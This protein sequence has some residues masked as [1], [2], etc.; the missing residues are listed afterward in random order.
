MSSDPIGAAN[1]A[2]DNTPT[3]GGGATAIRNDLEAIKKIRIFHKAIVIETISDPSIVKEAP[4]SLSEFS[5]D[6]FYQAPRNSIVARI[7]DDE[8]ST[9][10]SADIVSYPFLSSHIALP[11]K[12]GE[13]VWIFKPDLFGDIRATTSYWISRVH[14]ILP[15]ED[16]NYTSP[17]RDVSNLLLT[18]SIAPDKRLEDFPNEVSPSVFVLSPPLE[19]GKKAPTKEELQGEMK[20]IVKE[21][22]EAAQV[23]MEPAPR[24][25]KRPGDLVLQGSNNTSIC[26]GIDRGF[27]HAN[28]PADRKSSNSSD[29]PAEKAGSI[30]IVAGRGRYFDTNENEIKKPRKKANIGGSKNSTAPFVVKNSLDKFEVDKD[31]AASQETDDKSDLVKEG[32]G[33]PADPG[34]QKTNPSEGDPDFLA[35]AARIYISEKSEIDKKLGLDVIKAK[36]FEAQPTPQPP[37]PV[38]AVKADH[39]RIVARKVPIKATDSILPDKAKDSGATNGSIRIVKEG[40]PTTDLACIYIEPDGTIQISGNKIYM[41]RAKDTDGGAGNGP[42]A[43]ESQPYV[44]YKELEDLWKKL[45]DALNALCTEMNAAPTPG[46]G[47]PSPKI[48]VALA[49]LKGKI[50]GIK[51]DIAKVKSDRIFGE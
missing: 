7:I 6:L 39:I 48:D 31:P 38:V 15:L 10:T 22:A 14:D 30:D 20:R 17:T 5:G 35:D 34:N 33:A 42:G 28:R 13:Q 2:T 1:S 8:N 23:I 18:A 26:L 29:V 16:A 40:D 36:G 45:C 41:G 12:S 44:K 11:V 43:G 24:M 4:A 25:T 46:S 37:A 27:D 21:S 51:S 9:A 47:A 3:D 49:N 50:P 19:K 32:V